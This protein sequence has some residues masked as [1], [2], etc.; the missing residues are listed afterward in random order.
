LPIYIGP[1]AKRD[2]PAGSFVKIFQVEAGSGSGSDRSSCQGFEQVNRVIDFAFHALQGNG[3]D[4][5][6]GRAG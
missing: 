4:F 2:F 3:I 1:L 6:L 5:I